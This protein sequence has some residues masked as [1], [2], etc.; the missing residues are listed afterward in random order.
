MGRGRPKKRKDPP[1]D[2]IVEPEPKSSK[3]QQERSRETAG[4]NN[5]INY[6]LFVGIVKLISTNLIN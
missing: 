4:R 6:K 3:Q 5:K 1:E 2:N